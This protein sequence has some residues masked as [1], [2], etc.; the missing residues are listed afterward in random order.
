MTT[1]LKIIIDK[2][3]LRLLTDSKE[4]ETIFIEGGYAS[5][6]LSC[7]MTGAK[8]NDI[9]VTLIASIN[10]VAVAKLLELPAIIITEQSHPDE[11]TIARANQ[12]GVIL[13]STSLSNFTV[14]GSLWELGVRTG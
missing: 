4:F 2:L 6:L 10:I 11:M 7:V 3:Q 9:W 8:K 1:S 13:F 5:D 14:V 12:E